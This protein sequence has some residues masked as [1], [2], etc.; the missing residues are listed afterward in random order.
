MRF[1]VC[2]T[3]SNDVVPCVGRRD[4][5]DHSFYSRRRIL[6][7]SIVVFAENHQ[8]M[9]N[10]IRR[11]STIVN[12]LSGVDEYVGKE[13]LLEAVAGV[14]DENGACGLRTLQRDIRIIEEVFGME[15]RYVRGKGY[16]I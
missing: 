14:K 9:L 3:V 13:A 5:R 1:Y 7:P 2:R 8:S 10:Q 15:I 6:S 11:L 12:R 4:D 16:H